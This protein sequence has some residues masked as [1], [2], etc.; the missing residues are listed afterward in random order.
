MY[1]ECEK[2]AA[3]QTVSRIPISGHKRADA[4]EGEGLQRLI[5]PDFNLWPL[6]MQVMPP[7][8]VVAGAYCAVV[9]TFF[10]T[11]KTVN[12]RLH[13]MFDQGEIVEKKNS[14][15]AEGAK[16]EEEATADE[17]NLTR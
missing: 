3:L 5:T 1:F 14:A 4:F 9:A 11:V 16:G 15:L 17:G 6:C 13:T 12:F 2:D 8:I 7:S 10:T